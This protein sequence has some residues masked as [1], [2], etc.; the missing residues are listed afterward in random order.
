MTTITRKQQIVNS[1]NHSVDYRT[2]YFASEA[3][4][5]AYDASLCRI[6]ARGLDVSKVA[7]AQTQAQ[8]L[9]RTL[10]RTLDADKVARAQAE[11][12]WIRERFAR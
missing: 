2:L 11:S 5:A 6:P 7:A 10:T 4:A 8:A 3:D 9:T 1:H 12:E